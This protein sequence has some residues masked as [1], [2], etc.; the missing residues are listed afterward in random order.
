[1]VSGFSSCCAISVALSRRAGQNN[2]DRFR[3][4]HVALGLEIPE[5]GYGKMTSHGAINDVAAHV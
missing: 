2:H 1:M 5:E 4:I 3:V